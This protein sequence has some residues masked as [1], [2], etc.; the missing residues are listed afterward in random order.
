M[1]CT[2]DKRQAFALTAADV[3]VALCLFKERKE[4]IHISEIVRHDVVEDGE[5]ALLFCL[6]N[7]SGS[8]GAGF[9]VFGF[10]LKGFCVSSKG[11]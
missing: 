6:P 9:L 2:R 5:I 1:F 7:T 11:S 8:A 4:P 3:T 10:V